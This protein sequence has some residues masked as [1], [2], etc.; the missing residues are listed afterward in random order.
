MTSTQDGVHT[1]TLLEAFP[2]DS[3]QYR[4]VARNKVGETSCVCNLTVVGMYFKFALVKL[5]KVDTK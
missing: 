1:L 2:E 3:G 5:K 4:C